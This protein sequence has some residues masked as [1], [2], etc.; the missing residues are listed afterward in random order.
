MGNC[1]VTKLKAVVDNPNL[2][3]MTV[4]SQEVRAIMT[5]YSSD[6]DKTKAYYLQ[7]FFDTIGSTLKGKLRNMILPLFAVN[8]AEAIYDIIQD[9]SF[10]PVAGGNKASLNTENNRV[11]ITETGNPWP[12]YS[13]QI[14]ETNEYGGCMTIML[15]NFEAPNASFLFGAEIGLNNSAVGEFIPRTNNNTK[16]IGAGVVSVNGTLNLMRLGDNAN[17]DRLTERTTKPQWFQMYG[18]PFAQI[19]S[20]ASLGTRILVVVD[21]LLTPAEAQLLRDAVVTLDGKFYD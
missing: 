9:G 3:I 11:R 8:T 10:L 1:L 7:Q 17:A 2:P 13:Y 16:I 12:N 18:R 4:I 15:S 21:Q 20:D 6:P 19:V 14:K 5:H